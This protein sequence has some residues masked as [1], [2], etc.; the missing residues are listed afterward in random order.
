M[1]EVYLARDNRLERQVALKVLL[2]QFSGDSQ[3]LGRFMREAKAAS[4]LNHP[5]ILTIYEIGQAGESHYIAAE[6]IEG[7]TLRQRIARGPIPLDEALRIAVQAAAALEA[8]HSARVVHRDIKPENIMVRPDGLV[9][10]LD[11][12]LARSETTSTGDNPTMT[13]TATIMGTPRYM[14]P[15]QARGERV[16]AGTDI[17]SLG[18]VLYEILSGKPAFPGSTLADVFVSLVS[19][20]PMPL[21]ASVSNLPGGLESVLGKALAKDRTQR[22]ASMKEFLADLE[23]IKACAPTKTGNPPPALSRR[24]FV[25]AGV[26]AATG[27][28]YGAYKWIRSGIWPG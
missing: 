8:A 25:P 24:M 9:K 7:E 18:A 23:R 10:V 11:F 21:N 6:Y 20:E 12:G 2:P 13:Q 14:S 19:K 28:G 16:D 27:A 4:A 17:F 5:N 22:Y 15:E 1:G 26:I 3:W